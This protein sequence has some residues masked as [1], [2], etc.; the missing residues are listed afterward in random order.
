MTGKGGENIQGVG[1]AV[2]AEVLSQEGLRLPL[3]GDVVLTVLHLQREDEHDTDDNDDDDNKDDDDGG[4]DDN[5]D[6]DDADSS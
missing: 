1:R 4:G 2:D 3:V 6:D 5:S